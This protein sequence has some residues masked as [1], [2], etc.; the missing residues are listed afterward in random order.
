M[1]SNSHKQKTNSVD[2]GIV[3]N[4]TTPITKSP[5]Q[6][7]NNFKKDLVNRIESERDDYPP[8]KKTAMTD[9]KRW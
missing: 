8:V 5:E 1:T 6:L 3:L 4:N 9:K 2:S 7:I